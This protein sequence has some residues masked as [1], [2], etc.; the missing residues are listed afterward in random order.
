[1]MQQQ[2]QIILRQDFLKIVQCVIRLMHTSGQVPGLIIASFRLIRVI[3]VLNVHSVI[4][5]VTMLMQVPNATPVTSRII[6][7]P[8]IPIIRQW[9][10]RS[11]AKFVIPFSQA[12]NRHHL[13]SM[14][15]NIS[16]FIPGDIMEHGIPAHNVTQVLQIIRNTHVFR[17][18]S[19][20]KPQWIAN[21]M[22]KVVTHTSVQ[23]V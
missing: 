14:T 12:G 19:T 2:I 16:R 8:L 17:A 18:M 7:G 5:Q 21:T 15:P 4:P 6:L 1:M 11:H 9:D 23:R 10:F 20:I 13:P 3:Q 22:R